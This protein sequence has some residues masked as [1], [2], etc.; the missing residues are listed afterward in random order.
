MVCPHCQS[1]AVRRVP[2][3]VRLFRNSVRT[4]G[5]PP[6][7]PMPDVEVCLDC[8]LAQFRIP[9]HWLAAGWLGLDQRTPRP[10]VH[11]LDP[12]NAIEFL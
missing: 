11:T 1:N 4:L 6:M 10:L 9:E 2:A 8:G 7:T 3:E 5:H 12:L